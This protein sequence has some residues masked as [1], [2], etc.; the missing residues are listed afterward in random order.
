MCICISGQYKFSKNWPLRPRNLF[1]RYNRF[2]LIL[3]T[4]RVTTNDLSVPLFHLEGKDRPCKSND[5]RMTNQSSLAGT[6]D[7]ILSKNNSER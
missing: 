7:L 5:Q 4:V 6:L 2:L 3:F 1:L